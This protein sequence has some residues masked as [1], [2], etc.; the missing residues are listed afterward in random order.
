[1]ASTTNPPC[2]ARCGTARRPRAAGAGGWA[3]ITGAAAAI[4]TGLAAASI[5]GGAAAGPLDPGASPADRAAAVGDICQSV[6]RLW[7]MSADYHACVA[8]LSRSLREAAHVGP[9]AIGFAGDEPAPSK[10]YAYASRRD[11]FRREQL[12]CARL[13]LDPGSGAFP[14]CV[15]SLDSSLFSADNPQ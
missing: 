9:M 13:G 8:S 3:S 15:A 12:S 10:S 14:S 5:A 7:P 1:M 11:T 2:A 4:A 6:M